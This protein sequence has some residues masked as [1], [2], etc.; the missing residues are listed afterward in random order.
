MIKDGNVFLNWQKIDNYNESFKLW[1]VLNVE[2]YIQDKKILNIKKSDNKLLLLNKPVGYIVS[3]S[4]NQWKNIYD[5]LPDKYKNRYYIWRL[6]KDSC[7]LI[8]L[9]GDSKFVNLY[10]HPSNKI[11]KEYEVV[12]N[13]KLSD[14]DINKTLTWISDKDE[15]LFFKNIK[16]IWLYNWKK[17][18]FVYKIFLEEGKNRHIRRV[19]EYFWLRVVSLKRLREW[20]FSLWNLLSWKYVEVDV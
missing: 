10:S 4:N 7:G 1:D 15:K 16:F 17:N 3:K 19:F 13:Q 18:L 8:L 11:E 14:L 2:W 6:D 20:K 12:V 5:I 9:T